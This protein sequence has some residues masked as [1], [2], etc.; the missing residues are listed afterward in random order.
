MK[1][2]FIRIA[3]L[4]F[5]FSSLFIVGCE[6]EEAY[7]DVDGMNPELQLDA[8][9]QHIHTAA[10]HDAVIAAHLEDADGISTIQLI[11]PELYLDK[12][13]DLIEIY[14]EPKTSYDL[15]YKYAMKRD[16]LGER[17]VVKVI[18]TDVGGRTSG[19]EI[20]ISM[21]KDFEAP[22][23]VLSVDKKLTVLKK[24]E[25]RFKLKFKVTDNMGLDNIIINM[26]GVE[27]LQNKIV[28]ATGLKEFA[29]EEVITLPNEVKQYTLSV[30]ARDAQENKTKIESIVSVDKM[31]DF[32]KMYLADVKTAEELNSDLMGVPMFVE[33]AYDD[34]GDEIP[35]KYSAYYYNEKAG[36]EVR[37]IPQKTD[38]S[39]ICFGLGKDDATKL[40]EGYEETN[41]IVLTET[42]VY[43]QID[44]DIMNE[45]VEVFTYSV[46]D[47]VDPIPHEFGSTSLDLWGD[48]SEMVDFYFG[49]TTEGPSAINRFIQDKNNPHLFYS[50][51]MEFAAGEEMNFII[52]NYH[53]DG[54]WNYCTWRSDTAEDPEVFG[55]YGSVVNPKW[56]E[57]YGKNW[58]SDN[59]TYLVP[60]QAGKYK[61]IFDAHLGR[62]KFIPVK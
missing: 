41:P 8:D 39:P 38:F 24:V 12:T 10:G 54:W 6:Q 57:L 28:D 62:A 29:F 56:E 7:P 19:V 1:Q 36:T 53:P 15:D 13:I 50:E 18:V 23:F 21:D 43:Y 51:P 16:E 48:G 9:Q 55:Y 4:L 44:F 11:C 2:H 31:P 22:V 3:S 61:L 47:A 45:T 14:G 33:H 40:L 52:H 32:E 42:G 17:F 59:W 26:D 34:N 60:A 35:Y 27:G 20:P 49:F 5:C 37:F 58:V 46:A 25:T 30:V